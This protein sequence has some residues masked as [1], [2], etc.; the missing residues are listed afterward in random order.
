MVTSN[1]QLVYVLRKD[2]GKLSR[3]VHAAPR[4]ERQRELIIRNFFY[5]IYYRNI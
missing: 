5:T 4:P 1:V 2:G 3:A